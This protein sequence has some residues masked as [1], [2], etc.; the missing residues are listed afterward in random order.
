VL[1]LPSRPDD[2]PVAQFSATARPDAA[3]GLAGPGRTGT[4]ACACGGARPG[5]GSD[6]RT[7]GPP[8]RASCRAFSRCGSRRGDR[9]DGPECGKDPCE[10][11]GADRARIS[12]RRD[13]VGQARRAEATGAHISRRAASGCATPRRGAGKQ[14]WPFCER[15][16]GPGHRRAQGIAVAGFRYGRRCGPV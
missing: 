6:L 7:T 3:A 14:G 4:R 15:A 12:A 10:R 5:A 11:S 9:A 2:P 1:Q 16:A 8:D 13:P